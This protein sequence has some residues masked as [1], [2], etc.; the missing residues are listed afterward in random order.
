MANISTKWRQA[1]R[2]A[3][4]RAA[5]DKPAPSVHDD[6]PATPPVFDAEIDVLMMFLKHDL[7]ALINPSMTILRKDEKT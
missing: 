5:Q 2:A 7:D 3:Q 4:Q 6:F 1:R